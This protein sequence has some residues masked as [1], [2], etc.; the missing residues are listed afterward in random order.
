ME[1]TNLQSSFNLIIKS[2]LGYFDSSYLPQGAI[3]LFRYRVNL[4]DMFPVAEL[5]FQD[6][7]GLYTNAGLPESLDINVQVIDAETNEIK[8][9]AMTVK[10][11]QGEKNRDEDFINTQWIIDLISKY[12][13]KSLPKKQSLKG[14]VS[15]IVRQV[16]ISDF[17]LDSSKIFIYPTSDINTYHVRGNK[18]TEDFLILLQEQAFTLDYPNSPFVCFFDV[19]QNFWFY[20]LEY[21]FN[22]VPVMD[23]S[24]RRHEDVAF[25]TENMKTYRFFSGDLDENL[26]KY[27]TQIGKI[28]VDGSFTEEEKSLSSVLPKLDTSDKFYVLK[29][30]VEGKIFNYDSYG[31]VDS[32]EDYLLKG[33]IN[34]TYLDSLLTNRFSFVTNFDFSFDIGKMLNLNINTV[35]DTYSPFQSGKYMIIDY[36]LFYQNTTR[37][38]FV[39]LTVAKTGRII[40]K[41]NFFYGK[42]I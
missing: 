37:I 3:N 17:E 12:Y 6:S 8:S 19:F 18:N 34:S 14:K 33:R 28:D 9:I 30:F 15:D 16:V 27:N 4:Y 2:D 32:N 39:E 38:P 11:N 20:P 10:E 5:N 25:T 22:Q 29:N 24:I 23:I 42:T 21:F 36:S 7:V 41:E 26:Y 40:D 1:N 13:R 35:D 31:L